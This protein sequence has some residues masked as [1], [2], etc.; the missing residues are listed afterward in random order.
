MKKQ[1]KRQVTL[2]DIASLA[3]VTPMTVSRVIN[4]T[5]YVRVETRERVLQVAREMNY[6]R[7]GLARALKRQRTWRESVAHRW[8]TPIWPL[9]FELV[10]ASPKPA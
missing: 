3:S 10:R 6:R 4:G 5:G 8:W 2:A 1:T 7:N 9:S